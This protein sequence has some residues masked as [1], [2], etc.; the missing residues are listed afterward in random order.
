TF[1]TIPQ[2]HSLRLSLSAS[3]FPAHPVNAGT[4]SYP[5]ASRAIDGSIIT[6]KV[7]CQGNFPEKLLLPL[8]GE[9]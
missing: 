1:I 8:V 2:G 7:F 4:G 3:C 9:S 5:H 6:I